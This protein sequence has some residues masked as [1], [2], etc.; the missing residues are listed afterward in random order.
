MTRPRVLILATLCSFAL[1]A[2]AADQYAVTYERNATV[3]MRDGVKLKADIYRPIADGKFPVLLQRTPYNKDNEV[4]FGLKAAQRG[5]V[6]I[7][8]DVRGRYASEGEW[9]TFKNEPNDGYDSVEWAAA[10]PYSDGRVGMFGGSYVGAT[11]MLAAIA[12]PPHL[13]GICP[14]VTASNYHENWTYTGGAFEQWFNESWTSGLAQN[15]MTRAVS[16]Q[17]NALKGMW[18][19]PLTS[20]PLFNFPTTGADASTPTLA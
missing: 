1:L 4:D 15:T 16:A 19:L 13:A 5:F 12:H 6:V 9:Y 17:T 18:Q 8:E 14:V 2:H 11:Q 7:V 20:Y 10:L 3:T